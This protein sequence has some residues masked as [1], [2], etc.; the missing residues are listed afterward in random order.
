MSD[1]DSP[2]PGERVRARSMPELG[3]GIVLR[4]GP[5]RATVDWEND[6]SNELHQLSDLVREEPDQ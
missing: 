6:G 2:L 5:V 1:F 3:V 4:V